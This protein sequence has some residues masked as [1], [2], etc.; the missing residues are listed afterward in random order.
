MFAIFLSSVDRF[1]RASLV[2]CLM[3]L[4]IQLSPAYV[5]IQ[6]NVARLHGLISFEGSAK[7][8]QVFFSLVCLDRAWS[9]EHIVGAVSL[10]CERTRNIKPEQFTIQIFT[11][12]RSGSILVRYGWDVYGAQQPWSLF[13]SAVPIKHEIR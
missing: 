5:C 10:G 12:L 3:Q 1:W 13:C 6:A 4:A 8:V 2:L 9:S 11:P 7:H